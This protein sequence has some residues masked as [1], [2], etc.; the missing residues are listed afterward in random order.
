MILLDLWA[1]RRAKCNILHY[2]CHWILYGSAL[3]KDDRSYYDFT[4]FIFNHLSLKHIKLICQLQIKWK[5]ETKNI[6][7]V[8]IQILLQAAYCTGRSE[9]N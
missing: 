7:S 5:V 3:N 1:D 8:V 4:I 6:L 2:T 9:I